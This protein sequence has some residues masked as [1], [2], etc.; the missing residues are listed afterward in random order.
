[1]LTLEERRLLLG[2]LA[3]AMLGLAA[4]YLHL[5]GEQPAPYQPQGVKQ[6]EQRSTR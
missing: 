5:R 6:L 3:I 4:R 2:I 1:M